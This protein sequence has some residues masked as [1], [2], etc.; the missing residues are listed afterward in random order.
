MKQPPGL[1]LVDAVAGA[2][3]D[4][5]VR[6]LESAGHRVVVCHGPA[7]G[8]LCPLLEGTGCELVDES[9]G[10][11]FTL[12]LDRPQ[13]RAILR[14]YREVVRDDIPIRAVVRPGQ[15]AQYASVLEG[16]EV[17]DHEPNVA[18]LDGFAAEVEGAERLR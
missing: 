2:D 11:V 14:R 1:I 8:T 16:V 4:F 9:H 7:H 15:S 6:I 10:I 3:A 18:E 12:D 17:W 13:H 5:D